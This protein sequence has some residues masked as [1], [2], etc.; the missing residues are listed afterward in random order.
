MEDGNNG[1]HFVGQFDPENVQTDDWMEIIKTKAN[2]DE[3]A[4]LAEIKANKS[5]FED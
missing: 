4:R 2:M 3:L 5:D 1:D